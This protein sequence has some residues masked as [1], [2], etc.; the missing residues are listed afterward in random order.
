MMNLYSFSSKT[1]CTNI[2][3]ILKLSENSPFQFS[4][5]THDDRNNYQVNLLLYKIQETLWR[6]LLQL[7]MMN[8]HSFS[9]KTNCTNKCSIPKLSE[10]SSFQVC[11]ITH[12]DRNN[13]Q[14]TFISMENPVSSLKNNFNLKFD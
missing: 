9:S 7:K 4:S 12:N 11:N 8:L 6:T 10:N 13:Y 3:S 14:V 1:H 5:I 2:F